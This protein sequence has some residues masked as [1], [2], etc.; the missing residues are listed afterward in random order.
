M[1]YSQNSVKLIKICN[2]FRKCMGY[3]LPN[4]Y[5][6]PENEAMAM[7]TEECLDE[8]TINGDPVIL[9]SLLNI[10]V[11]YVMANINT[12]EY[13]RINFDNLPRFIIKFIQLLSETRKGVKYGNSF[14]NLLVEFFNSTIKER[15]RLSSEILFTALKILNEDFLFFEEIENEEAELKYMNQILPYH[16]PVWCCRIV[17]MVFETE[18]NWSLTSSQKSTNELNKLMITIL[19]NSIQPLINDDL[20]IS[21]TD[22]FENEKKILNF[23]LNKLN[24]SLRKSLG[25]QHSDLPF[26][27]ALDTLF[28]ETIVKPE[29]IFLTRFKSVIKFFNSFKLD[30]ESNYMVLGNYWLLI[31]MIKILIL[32]EG[33]ID[34]IRKKLVKANY[35]VEEVRE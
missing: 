11:E 16:R 25:F 33:K 3:S 23:E 8:S 1:G 31:G 6:P 4:K 19:P 2:T 15:W 9:R 17:N 10:L 27:K 35:A 18:K 34:P 5:L 32:H 26:E 28:K 12:D 7:D 21:L 20:K 30:E 13:Q 22:S 29:M 24:E 14:K